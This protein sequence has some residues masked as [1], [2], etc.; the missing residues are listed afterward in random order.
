MV[1]IGLDPAGMSKNETGIAVFEN[2]KVKT[3][4]VH[5]DDEILEVVEK[6]G[7]ELIA[8]DA[9]L[10]KPKQGSFREADLVLREYGTLPLNMR[11]M[12]TLTERGVGL[13][14]KLSKYKVIEVFPRAT[15]IIL[16]YW[17]K[18]E[19]RMQKKILEFG[20]TGD[21]EKR[22]LTKDEVDAISA[23][24]TGYLYLQ[25]KAKEVGDE[26]GKIIIPEV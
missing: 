14:E 23:A 21:P 7:P 22:M 25:G 5:E 24:I 17:D 2:K 8:V 3:H 19:R 16:G 12:I 4:L 1:V 10:S 13:K 18:D 6:E 26:E 15:D 20:I 11:G 9:P